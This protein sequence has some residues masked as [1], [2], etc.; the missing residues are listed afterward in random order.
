MNKIK[1]NV[2]DNLL[3]WSGVH[4]VLDQW[5]N[6]TLWISYY[7]EFLLG[8]FDNEPVSESRS[9]VLAILIGLLMDHSLYNQWI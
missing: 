7:T 4:L 1:Q 6:H 9:Y 5:F 8:S 2:L 3:N